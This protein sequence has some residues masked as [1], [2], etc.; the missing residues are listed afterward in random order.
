MLR[1]KIEFVVGKAGSAICQIKVR[2]FSL[3]KLEATE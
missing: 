3:N 1:R 2:K